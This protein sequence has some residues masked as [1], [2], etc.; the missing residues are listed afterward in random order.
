MTGWS[1]SDFFKDG[2]VEG[3][4]ALFEKGLQ[5]LGLTREQFPV[6]TVTYNTNREHQKI[7]QAIQQQWKKVLGINVELLHFDWKVYLSKI[8][9][10]DFEIGRMG[11]V[12][13]FNDPISFLEPFKYKN[14]PEMGGNNDTGWEDPRYIALLDGAEQERDRQKRAH[15]LH[16]AEALLISEMPVIPIY[17]LMSG[18]LKKPYVHGVYLSPLGT[19]DF[20]KA[21]ITPHT[22]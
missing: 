17:F 15:L 7:A 14:D 19:V 18:Y 16:Q 12:G 2:D 1:P 6:L 11:W 3:A 4:K 9:K 10:Q 22:Q 8:S 13:D 20:K 21:Y 5:E